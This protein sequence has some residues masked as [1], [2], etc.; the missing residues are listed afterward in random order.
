MKKGKRQFFAG[1]FCLI[2]SLVGIIPSE[3]VSAANNFNSSE[4]VTI[5]EENSYAVTGAYTWVKYKAP[6]N[7]YITVTASSGLPKNTVSSTSTTVTIKDPATGQQSTIPRTYAKG[8]WCLYNSKKSTALSSNDAFRTNSTKATDLSQ[9]YGVKKN[10]TY[11]L[12]V[13]S[14]SNL[15][16]KCK[17]TKISENSGSSKAKAKSIKKNTTVKGI[18]A[19]GDKAVDWYKITLPKKQVLHI[20]FSGKTNDKIKIT[21]SG[22]YLKT[23]KKYIVKGNINTQHTYTTE[24]AQPGNYYVKVERN[25]SK[26]SGSYTLK[27]K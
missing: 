20:Y 25:N 17:F 14:D 19:A 1:I 24:R 18:I 4:T 2:L 12:R 15:S 21:F 27:W 13:S 5:S 7:G 8:K 26:S 9:T 3:K 10:T 16:I 11:Y 23:A 6:N 22:T